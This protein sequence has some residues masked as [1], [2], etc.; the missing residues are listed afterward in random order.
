MLR[1][2]QNTI[3]C[4]AVQIQEYFEEPDPKT[5]EGCGCDNCVLTSRRLSGFRNITNAA[6]DMIQLLDSIT[7]DFSAITGPKLVDVFKGSR[8]AIVKDKGWDKY[9]GHG[10]NSKHKLPSACIMQL[11]QRLVCEGIFK[12]NVVNAGTHWHAYLKVRYYNHNNLLL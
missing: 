11:W 2:C 10:A 4:R 8:A 1:F 12:H 9:R 6:K 3:Q 7:R 5:P